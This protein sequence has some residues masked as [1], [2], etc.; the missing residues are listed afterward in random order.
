MNLIFKIIG[1]VLPLLTVG[2]IVYAAWWWNRKQQSQLSD[3]DDVSESLF[4]EVEL[5]RDVESDDNVTVAVDS[6]PNTTGLEKTVEVFGSTESA[7]DLPESLPEEITQ[8]AAEFTEALG[9]DDGP[10]VEI[11]SDVDIESIVSQLSSDKLDLTETVGMAD[12]SVETLASASE[13]EHEAVAEAEAEAKV[14][15]VA[16]EVTEMP[17]SGI[18]P[19]ESTEAIHPEAILPA[20]IPPRKSTV[21]DATITPTIGQTESVPNADHFRSRPIPPRRE[22]TEPESPVISLHDVPESIFHSNDEDDS[23]EIRVVTADEVPDSMVTKAE[24][25]DTQDEL[26]QL[27]LALEASHNELS[28][29]T[30]SRDQALSCASQQESQ[31][32]ALQR[33][34]R[35]IEASQVEL[36][37][38]R[39][40]LASLVGDLKANTEVL[41][42]ELQNSQ[43]KLS[44]AQQQLADNS[45]EEAIK[46]I[47]AQHQSTVDELRSVLGQREAAEASL[48]RE[49]DALAEQNSQLQRR[50]DALHADLAVVS[51]V[52]PESNDSSGS[53]IEQPNA[54]AAVR[55]AELEAAYQQYSG[56]LSLANE[57]VRQ[58]NQ[59]LSQRD[60]QLMNLRRDHDVLATEINQLKEAEAAA[61][62]AATENGS[63]LTELGNERD[64]ALS[65]L[66]SMKEELDSAKREVASVEGKNES[67]QREL[68]EA[69]EELTTEQENAMTKVTTEEL[70]VLKTKLGEA[71]S[72]YAALIAQKEVLETDFAAE[73]SNYIQEIERLKATP[74]VEESVVDELMSTE[75]SN[76][77]SDAAESDAVDTERIDEL[78]TIL[79]QHEEYVKGLLAEKQDLL[80]RLG[81]SQEEINAKADEMRRIQ[82]RLGAAE[83]AATIVERQTES[84]QDSETQVVKLSEELNAGNTELKRLQEEQIELKQEL[85]FLTDASEAWAAERTGLFSRLGLDVNGEPR[86]EEGE[87]TT[88]GSGAALE[89]TLA[90]MA[91][92]TAALEDRDLAYGQLQKRFDEL[93]GMHESSGEVAVPDDSA[94]VTDSLRADRDQAAA[95]A[96]EASATIADLMKEVH[97]LTN[98]TDGNDAE[99]AKL[100]EENQAY[101]RS[102]SELHAVANELEELKTERSRE[103]E[104]ARQRLQEATT[105]NAELNAEIAA[106]REELSRE[107]TSEMEAVSEVDPKLLSELT[108]VRKKLRDLNA[109]REKQNKQISELIAQLD[110]VPQDR[111]EAGKVARDAKRLNAA[112]AKSETK[113][114]DRDDRLRELASELSKNRVEVASL[115]SQLTEQQA[116]MRALKR[117]K[118]E[119]VHSTAEENGRVRKKT[120]ESKIT[121]KP[122]RGRAKSRKKYV[123]SPKKSARTP[124]SSTKKDP[125]LGRVYARRPS[126][127]D[128]LKLITGIGPV[129]EKRLNTVG[130][131]QF[132]QV[133][134]WSKSTIDYLDEALSLSGRISRDKWVAQAKKL[135]RI[136][137]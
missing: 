89:E 137:R 48:A 121:A 54:Q 12:V 35:D 88:S 47:E 81:A 136:A 72:A 40:T 13:Q 132:D 70:E 20:P 29:L 106:L 41:Q 101:R 56:E 4:D 127:V 38:E 1:F 130:I 57:T 73:K 125:K 92:L 97:E 99:V 98:T 104:S 75:E 107:S 8:P 115:K 91:R 87:L 93:Q 90:E 36:Q 111:K 112:L 11:V 109:E 68:S 14:E 69:K 133:R 76:E 31:L 86:G 49:R 96:A 116:V 27:R 124:A 66:E 23:G 3:G 53:P 25:A 64:R 78:E 9:Q 103:Q 10:R 84:L 108:E 17:V 134:A 65:F 119:N 114:H 16:D 44:D 129:L 61:E 74:V 5:P 46:E 15:T 21:S 26:G 51:A 131:Y 95:A 18:E 94:G 67:L 52:T 110:S 34:I 79:E 102:V 37:S 100:A 77:V 32:T 2:L 30:V 22:R 19:T 122:S 59:N 39:E 126:A 42:T 135:S 33:Q 83:E 28:H 6:E 55:I 50:V 24:Y 128:D 117:G 80:D 113:L 85:A 120:A 7:A 58:L 105:A 82:D 123:S 45:S 62:V 43:E 71:T 60:A 118:S 63:A